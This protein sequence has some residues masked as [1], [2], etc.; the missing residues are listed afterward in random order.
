MPSPYPPGAMPQ[1]M[2]PGAYTYQTQHH[3]MPPNARPPPGPYSQACHPPPPPSYSHPRPPNAQIDL[4]ALKNLFEL[5]AN[6]VIKSA[7]TFQE[8]C[9]QMVVKA[10]KVGQQRLESEMVGV[11]SGIQALKETIGG[12]KEEVED[13]KRKMGDVQEACK[14]REDK[15]QVL[16]EVLPSTIEN[17]C[18]DSMKKTLQEFKDEA[19]RGAMEKTPELMASMLPEAMERILPA[20]VERIL[21]A[22]VERI[23]PALVES[24]NAMEKTPELVAS[25]LPEEMAR[26]LPTLVESHDG[27][28]KMFQSS[29]EKRLIEVIESV[30]MRVAEKAP[31]QPKTKNM[32][33]QMQHSDTTPAPRRSA[34]NTNKNHP[35]GAYKQSKKRKHKY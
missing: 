15:M 23:S 22:L 17:L 13:V 26:I 35:I 24:R 27:M 18:H 16:A 14:A 1:Y 30:M 9:G 11:S 34:R 32:K 28:E 10:H 5:G 31:Q 29:V 19:L 12:I 21:P 25:M 2:G 4:N 7:R 3:G 6:N 8:E 20:L 33:R